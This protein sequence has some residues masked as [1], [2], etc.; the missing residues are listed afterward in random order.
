M[1][2]VIKLIKSLQFDAPEDKRP[3]EEDPDSGSRGKRTRKIE[4]TENEDVLLKRVVALVEMMQ[5]EVQSLRERINQ[6]K[7]YLEN[8]VF[9]PRA[10]DYVRKM[11]PGATST[12][13]EVLKLSTETILPTE[14]EEKRTDAIRLERDLKNFKQTVALFRYKIEK[15]QNRIRRTNAD[16]LEKRRLFGLRLMDNRLHNARAWIDF[17]ELLRNSY[18]VD[19]PESIIMRYKSEVLDMETTLEVE[20]VPPSPMYEEELEKEKELIP[21][22][23]SVERT[24]PLTF[25][26]VKDKLGFLDQKEAELYLRL[27]EVLDEIRLSMK[28]ARLNVSMFD[29]LRKIMR[30]KKLTDKDTKKLEKL[31]S[32]YMK[33]KN[34]SEEPS[35]GELKQYIN[36][37][38]DEYREVERSEFTEYQSFANSLDTFIEDIKLRTASLQLLI[39]REEINQ[40]N[41]GEPMRVRD[42]AKEKM[43]I[44]TEWIQFLQKCENVHGIEIKQDF[45][46]YFQ[47]KAE[48]IGQVFEDPKREL[49]F[50]L[51]EEGEDPFLVMDSD[52]EDEEDEEIEEIEEEEEEELGSDFEKDEPGMNDPG[53]VQLTDE[54]QNKLLEKVNEETNQR[55]SQVSGNWATLALIIAKE[56]LK[57]DP[58]RKTMTEDEMER[59][60][61]ERTNQLIAKGLNSVEEHVLDKGVKKQENVIKKVERK[62]GDY[63]LAEL[64]ADE[65][66]KKLSEAENYQKS[67]KT[68]LEAKGSIEQAQTV[69][70]VV[71]KRRPKQ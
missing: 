60:L 56:E 32:S 46:E 12:P 38:Y 54:E 18:N 8:A 70:T 30:L 65:L 5:R 34:L 44:V 40:Q 20:E 7:L 37:S 15:Y 36:R 4:S 1:D 25:D 50:N 14:L 29:E 11:Y 16:D 23:P 47:T 43:I 63:E 51:D 42:I 35:K 61:S 21:L 49:D 55:R 62:T 41:T 19:I 9:K 59:F 3:R 27:S 22:P 6:E 58:R 45:K 57:N 26:L 39:I 13:E 68:A 52:E 53:F 67:L 24:E 10:A 2:D 71:P 48:E 28:A 31:K 33:K 66:Q 64:S 69:H 17:L